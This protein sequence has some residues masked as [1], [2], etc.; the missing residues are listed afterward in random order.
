MK[1]RT[2]MNN[3]WT[4]L[5]DIRDGHKGEQPRTE[6]RRCPKAMDGKPEEVLHAIPQA[7]KLLPRSEGLDVSG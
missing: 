1:A 6:I 7:M 4:N 5:D 3:A 2:L